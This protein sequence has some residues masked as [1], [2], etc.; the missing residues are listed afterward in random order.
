MKNIDKAMKALGERLD[1]QEPIGRREY[2]AT[3]LK[4]VGVDPE[5]DSEMDGFTDEQLI[6]IRYFIRMTSDA[7]VAA[8][9]M[10]SDVKRQVSD[11]QDE[12]LEKAISLFI[13][14]RD[15][16]Q[17][18]LESASESMHA[19]KRMT[20]ESRL[21]RR[22]DI[23]SDITMHHMLRDCAATQDDYEHECHELDRLLEELREC[24]A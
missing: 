16:V 4:A 5:M 23:L 9:L 3:V 14:A 11:E 24:D 22:A 12:L 17:D 10:C 19:Q 18:F 15:T 8:R 2:A 7:V 1:Q 20:K 6:A 21:A 13:Q